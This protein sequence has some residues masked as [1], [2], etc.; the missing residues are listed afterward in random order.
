MFI[1]AIVAAAILAASTV[2]AAPSASIVARQGKGTIQLCRD[3][4][5]VDCYDM[6]YDPNQCSKIPSPSYLLKVEAYKVKANND[7]IDRFNDSI[8]SLGLKKNT[9]TFYADPDCNGASFSSGE[10]VPDIS[11]VLTVTALLD[12][13]ISSFQCGD[14]P[15]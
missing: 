11:K 7:K 13:K 4:G 2:T 10:D 15:A 12:N 9:C 6:T 8:T 1:N 5:Y 3:A 14:L